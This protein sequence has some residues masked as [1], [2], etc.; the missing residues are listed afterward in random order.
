MCGYQCYLGALLHSS[1]GWFLA[2]IC[3][4]QLGNHVSSSQAALRAAVFLHSSS[5][6]CVG[7]PSSAPCAFSIC[8]DSSARLLLISL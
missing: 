6:C 5:H 1:Q 4:W 3:S 2:C 7:S 8:I